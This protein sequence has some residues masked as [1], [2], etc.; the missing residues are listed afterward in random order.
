M[1]LVVALVTFNPQPADADRNAHRISQFTADAAQ[2]GA[3]IT[4]FGDLALSGRLPA[5]LVPGEVP[6]IPPASHHFDQPGLEPAAAEVVDLARETGRHAAELA[7]QL[8]QRGYGGRH[9]VVGALGLDPGSGSPVSQLLAMHKGRIESTYSRGGTPAVLQAHRGRFGLALDPAPT[10]YPAEV[11]AVFVG[12]EGTAYVTDR[13][14]GRLSHQ[15]NHEGL[16]LWHWGE[17]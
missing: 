3:D 5:G 6:Q 11:D 2:L 4:V 8:D 10:P 16:V 12:A 13:N 17:P 9:V 14:G 15:A 7:H 1:A